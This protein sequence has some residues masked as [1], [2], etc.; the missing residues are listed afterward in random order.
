MKFNNS[1]KILI[2][3]EQ[4]ERF[5][6]MCSHHSIKLYNI[7]KSESGYYASMDPACFFSLKSIA[8]KSE[9]KIKI[10]AKE[11][12]WFCLYTMRK[13]AMF[14]IFPIVCSLILISSSQFLWNVNL[15]GNVSIT[16]DMIKDYLHQKGIYYGMLLKEIPINQL[17]ADLRNEYPQINW[18]SVYLEGTT[19]QIA[20]KE[21]DNKIYTS[22]KYASSENIVA[23]T[24]GIVESVLI[25]KGTAAVKVGDE[26]KKGDILIKGMIDVPADDGSI[27][28]SVLCQADGDVVLICNHSINQSIPLKYTEKE[29][30]S[31][32][33]NKLEFQIH[34]KV[35]TIPNTNVPYLNYEVVTEKKE[36]AIFNIF[37]IPI[38]VNQNTYYEYFNKEYK[39]TADESEKIL[40]NK[41]EEICKT[42][43]EKGVQIIEKNV[44]IETNSVYSTMSGSMTLKVHC[45]NKTISEDNP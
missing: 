11:G 24:S 31:R 26:V 19:L 13:H 27:K 44:K 3:G 34:N 5:F 17:K 30:T 43:M 22:D 39:Y 25:R 40:N 1:I 33:L 12:I 28:Q 7:Y 14:F 36:I 45:G 23:S 10:I 32:K 9:V 21:N 37:S 8:K 2:I 15:E 18:V 16:Q 4:T 42:F 41:L 6:N 29:Y 35:Y 20:L 38:I